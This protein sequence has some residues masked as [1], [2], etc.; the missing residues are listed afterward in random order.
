MKTQ[1]NSLRNSRSFGTAAAVGLLALWGVVMASFFWETTGLRCQPVP[2]KPA[3]ARVQ[4]ILKNEQFP[5]ALREVAVSKESVMT[6]WRVQNDAKKTSK[7]VPVNVDGEEIPLTRGSNGDAI[8]QLEA[9]LPEIT[10]FLVDP[11]A[12]NLDISTRC[13]F[14]PVSWLLTLG[15]LALS[16]LLLKRTWSPLP[17]RSQ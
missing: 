11:R 4:C 2:G 15:V 17:V 3:Y 6:V 9:R 8:A 13:R 5:G 10:A 16:G 1:I 14:P 12:E 7:I